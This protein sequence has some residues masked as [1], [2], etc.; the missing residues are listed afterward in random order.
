MIILLEKKLQKPKHLKTLLTIERKISKQR[1]RKQEIGQCFI[2]EV[3][4]NVTFS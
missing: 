4:K 1:F 2:R 3:G